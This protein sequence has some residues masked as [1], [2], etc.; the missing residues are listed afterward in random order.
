M[1]GPYVCRDSEESKNLHHPTFAASVCA[2]G[3]HINV[4]G[5]KNAGTL[6]SDAKLDASV[7]SARHSVPVCAV[8][9]AGFYRSPQS[10][11]A[12][13]GGGVAKNAPIFR[14]SMM[15]L[16]KGSLSGK[17]FR[18]FLRCEHLGARRS[19]VMCLFT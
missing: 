14:F 3:R 17:Y 2:K 16:Y 6:P 5:F 12:S 9:Q 19:R 11:Q 10:L 7:P 1:E 8:I 15:F 18:L 13:I 4:H